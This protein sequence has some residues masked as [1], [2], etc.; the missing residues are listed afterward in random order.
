MFF[1]RKL[2]EANLNGWQEGFDVGRKKAVNET[3]KVYIKLLSQEIQDISSP[4]MVDKEY[5]DGLE[6]ALEIVKRGRR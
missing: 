1:K 4:M 3:R 5:L 2:E 6:R